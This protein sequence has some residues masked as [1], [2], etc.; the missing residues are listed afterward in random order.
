MNEVDDIQSLLPNAF[1]IFGEEYNIVT[2]AE[3]DFEQALNTYIEKLRTVKGKSRS[4]GNRRKLD[5]IDKNKEMDIFAFRQN[6]H[7]NNIDNIVVEL[8]HPNVKLGEIE[9]SQVKTYMNVITSA[10]EFNAP[11]MRW[12]FYLVGNDF[13]SSGYIP[14]EIKSNVNWGKEGLIQHVEENG[15]IYEIFVKKWSE[16]FSD[17]EIRHNFLLKKLQLK[18]MALSTKHST[19]EEIHQIVETNKE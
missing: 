18:R 8:K 7:S 1:W 6:I 5:H 13:D 15:I 17:F 2:E 12:K 10:P 4:R 11:N 19:K 3:P 9:V 14:R 16:L